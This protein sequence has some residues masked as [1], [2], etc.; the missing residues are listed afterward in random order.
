MSFF[1]KLFGGKK[2]STGSTGPGVGAVDVQ[3]SHRR[4]EPAPGLS[5]EVVAARCDRLERL[6]AQSNNPRIA[7]AARRIRERLAP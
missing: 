4:Q 5:R 1:G 2:N 6:A 7:V 3:P